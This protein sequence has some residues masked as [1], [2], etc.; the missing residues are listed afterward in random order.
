MARVINRVNG[1]PSRA[2]LLGDSVQG[3]S[4]RRI[5]DVECDAGIDALFSADFRPCLALDLAKD[6]GQGKNS[7]EKFRVV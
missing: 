5:F 6:I 3:G 7:G 2:G 1:G 4:E